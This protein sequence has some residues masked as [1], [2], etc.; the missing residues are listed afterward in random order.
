MTAHAGGVSAHLVG[1][2]VEVR[3]L[4][5]AAQRLQRGEPAGHPELVVF[6]D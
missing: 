1:G 5:Q 6:R 4:A 3:S 2:G